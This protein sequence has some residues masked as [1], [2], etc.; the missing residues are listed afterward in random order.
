VLKRFTKASL[1]PEGMLWCAQRKTNQ[2]IG[3]CRCIGGKMLY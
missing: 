1:L 3:L 2:R